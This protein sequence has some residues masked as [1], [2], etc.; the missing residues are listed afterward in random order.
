MARKSRAAPVFKNISRPDDED[1][2]NGDTP[3]ANS[4]IS[5]LADLLCEAGEFS[6]RGAALRFITAK[7]VGR[8]D[9]D[10]PWTRPKREDTAR[11]SAAAKVLGRISAHQFTEIVTQYAKER[12][13]NDRGDV[14]FS[15]VFNEASE[16]GAA[17]RQ[18]RK[19]LKERTSDRY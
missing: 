13:P 6:D 17:I 12:Y 4:P 11:P 16:Q 3:P 18:A 7:L 5:H 10:S 14:A 19:M 8:R 2:G 15:K 1:N 9:V